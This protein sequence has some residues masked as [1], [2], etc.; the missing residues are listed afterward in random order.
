MV[1]LPS[2]GQAAACEWR[3]D[4]AAGRAQFGPGSPHDWAGEQPSLREGGAPHRA[5]DYAIEQVTGAGAGLDVC[6]LVRG[7]AK[8]GGTLMDVEIGG[9]RTMLSYRPDLCVAGFQLRVE[10]AQIGDGTLA[11]LTQ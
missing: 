5:G 8:I 2:V 11:P 10:G 9:R 4:L 1:L 6:V 7:D 3:L